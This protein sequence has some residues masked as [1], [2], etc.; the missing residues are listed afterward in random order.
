MYMYIDWHNINDI[1]WHM[2]VL[3]HIQWHIDSTVFV[4]CTCTCIS[5]CICTCINDISWHVCVI[6]QI[7]WPIDST[8]TAAS[9]RYSEPVMI[10][11]CSSRLYVVRVGLRDRVYVYNDCIAPLLWL[12]MR[13][14]H[15]HYT[16][17][18]VGAHV[19]LHVRVHVSL[20]LMRDEKE[21]RKSNKQQGKATQ[22]TQVTCTCIYM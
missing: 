19:H 22:H 17:T 7:R 14:R 8:C 4:H 10:I 21:G 11:H 13:D 15:V 5:T 12:I 16:C 18:N 9:L 20:I 2:Y 6:N 3:N 1:S